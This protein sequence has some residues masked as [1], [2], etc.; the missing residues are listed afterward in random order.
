MLK[1]R[2]KRMKK[3]GRQLLEW[4]KRSRGRSKRRKTR[5]EQLK[6]RNSGNKRRLGK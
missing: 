6:W 4:R 3:E 1:S 2:S 5:S